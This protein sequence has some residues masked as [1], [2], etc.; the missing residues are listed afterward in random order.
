M[1]AGGE[2][3]HPLV[4]RDVELRALYG[5][6]TRARQG[7]A[8]VVVVEGEP[9]IGKSALLGTFVQGARLTG[10]RWL[11]CD[12]FAAGHAYGAADRLVGGEP[13]SGRSPVAAGRRVLGWFGERQDEEADVAVLVVDD[14][15]WLDQASANALQFAVRRL[16]ADRVLILVGRR[17]VPAA[18]GDLQADDPEAT[19]LLRPARLDGASVCAL[20]R[21][22]RGWDLGPELGDEVVTRTGGLPLFVT[23]VVR[24]AVDRDQLVSGTALPASAAT[25]VGRLLESLE[26]PARRL[27]EATAVLA[28]PTSLVVLGQVAEV[29]DPSA[30]LT[31]AAVSGLVISDEHGDVA[32]AHDLLSAAVRYGLSPARRRELHLRSATWTTGDR[33]LAHRTAASDRPNPLLVKELLAAAESARATLRYGTAAEHRLRAREVSPDVSERERLLVDALV[34][35]VEAQEL[36]R[37]RELAPLVRRGPASSRRSLALGLLAA[38]SGEVGSARTLLQESLD[39]ASGAGDDMAATRAAL[40][41][42]V[43][44]VRL[45]DGVAALKLLDHAGGGSDPEIATD[46]LTTTGIAL[47]LVGD[48]D[49]ALSLLGSYAPTWA[50]TPWEADLLGVRGMV[51]L[52]AGRLPEALRDLDAAVSLLHLWRPS[53]NQSRIFALRSTTRFH[54]GDWD[55]AAVDAAAARALAEGPTQLW[56]AALA[57]AVSVD[58]PAHRGRW[59]VAEDYLS[60]ALTATPPVAQVSDVVASHAAGAALAR[61][62]YAEV[63]EVLDPLWSDAFL[64]R[65]S[66]HGWLGPLIEARIVACAAVGRLTDAAEDLDRYEA[67]VVRWPGGVTPPRMGWLRGMLAEAR[68]KPRAARASYDSDLADQTM[69]RYPFER[70]QVLLASGRLERMLGNRRLAID[71]LTQARDVFAR[72]R[73][74]PYL[75][76]CTRELAACGLPSHLADPLALTT[77]EDD[78]VALVLRGYSNKEVAAELFLTTRTVEYHLRN[79][80]AKL[81]VSSRH[82]LRRRR[83]AMLET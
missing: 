9:G 19:T 27:V 81:G 39:L 70:A 69:A 32:C 53:T 65:R 29:A 46:V 72:L 31:S 18:V 23:A 68:R 14:A 11:R 77:R 22:V 42:A 58:V 8:Q 63:L 66:R 41:G 78:V 26:P 24:G 79:V 64:E 1:T 55:G 17:A 34:E 80:Y 21:R 38:E 12:E 6:L 71:R 35:Q 73:A 61:E 10:V 20:A 4:G 13:L 5:A 60:R 37:A 44:E 59:E 75:E 49:R 33:R 56:S 83:A 51:S 2:D 74:Q 45:G 7:R 50:G 67:L 16:R 62:D 40:A 3:R 43:L 47:W 28:E 30:A 25:A 54:V 52:Y 76:R 15:Q 48:P 36:D 82:E 57:L